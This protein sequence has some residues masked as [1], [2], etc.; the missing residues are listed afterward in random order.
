MMAGAGRRRGDNAASHPGSL[1]QLAAAASRIASS[2]G[3][4]SR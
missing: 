4:G 2:R 3:G 1:R